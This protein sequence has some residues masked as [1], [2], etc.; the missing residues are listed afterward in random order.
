MLLNQL[1]HIKVL[2]PP[3]WWHKGMILIIFRKSVVSF[4]RRVADQYLWCRRWVSSRHLEEEIRTD[5]FKPKDESSTEKK[6]DKKKVTCF[7][8]I[9]KGHYGSDCKKKKADKAKTEK[10]KD[11]S[12][13]NSITEESSHSTRTELLLAIEQT[14]VAGT[15]EPWYVDNGASKHMTKHKKLFSNIVSKENVWAMFSM[16]YHLLRICF[17]S[18]LLQWITCKWCLMTKECK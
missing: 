18:H 3:W 6:K 13:K 1:P 7:Y 14:R 11:S 9:K 8:F 10:D 16:F 17:L 4:Y 5:N 2:L 12:T 15:S